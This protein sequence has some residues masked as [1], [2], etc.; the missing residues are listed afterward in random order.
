MASAYDL[1][2]NNDT[3]VLKFEF[4]DSNIKES[5]FN[6]TS[7]ASNDNSLIVNNRSTLITNSIISAV[8]N[9][10]LNA[11][12]PIVYKDQSGIHIQVKLLE[13]NQNLN[14]KLVDVLGR[15]ICSRTIANMGSDKQQIDLLN[16]ETG[17]LKPGVYILNF[18]AGDFI[19][20]K[21]LLI[22]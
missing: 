1:G 16:S 15:V 22:K 8:S 14:I 6:L 17:Y 11:N 10:Q 19:C 18:N 21:K 3:L 4:L 12:Q 13:A 7:A 2:V 9:V 5:Q 20:S